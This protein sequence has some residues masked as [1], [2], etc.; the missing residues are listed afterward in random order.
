MKIKYIATSLLFFVFNPL[1][2]AEPSQTLLP[3]K[4][5]SVPLWKSCVGTI[6][7]SSAQFVCLPAKKP[8]NCQAN[9]WQKLVILKEL[10]RCPN[11]K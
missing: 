7:K 6:T 8:K 3:P 11:S 2:W 5:L 1:S 4:Y 9:S 10:D